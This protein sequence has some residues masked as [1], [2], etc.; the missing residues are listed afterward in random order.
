[1][2]SRSGQCNCGSVAISLKAN[3]SE[4]VVCHCLN[5]RRAG[6]PYSINYV[7]DDSEVI[8]DDLKHSLKEYEDLNTKSGNLVRRNFCQACGSPVYTKSI[9]MPGKLLVKASLFDEVVVARADVFTER[10]IHWA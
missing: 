1:M 7:L 8:I 2:A 4:T 3:P 9:T 6:G 5:C 10:K